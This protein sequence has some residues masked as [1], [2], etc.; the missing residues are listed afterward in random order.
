M[1]WPISG[2]HRWHRPHC[3]FWQLTNRLKWG[4]SNKIFGTCFPFHVC[5]SI[6]SLFVCTCLCVVIG[7]CRYPPA[8]SFFNTTIRSRYPISDCLR[9]PPKQPRSSRSINSYTGAI[10]LAGGRDEF[11]AVFIF[12]YEKNLIQLNIE[13]KFIDY[14]SCLTPLQQYRFEMQL[15]C[16]RWENSLF[17]ELRYIP[18]G[19]LLKFKYFFFSG[20]RIYCMYHV[21]IYNE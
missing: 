3:P 21:G 8:F 20:L 10:S 19:R 2:S 7:K 4:I 6:R 16:T 18:V 13:S 5:Y 12:N 14:I 11:W 15:P 17:R 9:H 1:C